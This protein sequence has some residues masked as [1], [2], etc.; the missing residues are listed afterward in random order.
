[1]EN[2]R[3]DLNAVP[4]DL[5]AGLFKSL[6]ARAEEA[7]SFAERIVAWRTRLIGGATDEEASLYRA[8]GKPYGPRRGPFQH[9]NELG[10]VLGLPPVLVERALPYLTVY[11]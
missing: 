7:D 9:I 2:A 4:K 11:S 3:I 8:A 6:G 10:L 5:L 1:S